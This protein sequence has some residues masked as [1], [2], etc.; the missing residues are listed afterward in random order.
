MSSPT[1]ITV[2]ANQITRNLEFPV[3]KGET[4]RFVDAESGKDLTLAEGTYNYTYT[5]LGCT[6]ILNVKIVGVYPA[7]SIISVQ[8]Q[9][10][11]SPVL[12]KYVSVSGK[13]TKVVTGGFYI[14]DASQAWSGI[15]VSSTATGIL[16]G[17]GV[18]VNGKV[19]EPGNVT[20]IV[21]DA[22][23]ILTLPNPLVPATITAVE[24]ATAALAQTEQ[25][26]S[27]LV[28]VK[29][30]TRPSNVSSSGFNANGAT[31]NIF[32][33]TSWYS[34][35]PNTNN[36][37]DITGIVL[38]NG[39]SYVLAPRKDTDVVNHS[40]TTGVP[41]DRELEFK[42]YPNPFDNELFIDNAN[43][44]SRVVVYNVAGQR[45][46]DVKYPGHAIRTASLVRGA[47][48]VTGFDT[49][50]NSVFTTRVIKK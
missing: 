9:A 44:L 5:Y 23:M 26:E 16:E 13:V 42:V 35:A 34:F 8:G 27:V 18:T 43:E 45:V 15:F 29:E 17:N 21:A 37:Y 25:Y 22:V 41:T 12:N 3:N 48:V 47:Y 7:Y 11:L 19:T 33:T 24:V 32:V 28:K 30:S 14:Q 49:D 38:N 20:T 10:D 1:S 6:R 39:T 36:W 31:S 2:A 4:Y 40:S 50:N 46:I